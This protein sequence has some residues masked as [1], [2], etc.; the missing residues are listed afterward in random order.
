M[1]HLV[2]VPGKHGIQAPSWLVCC[3]VAPFPAQNIDKEWDGESSDFGEEKGAKCVC[4]RL[5]DSLSLL[6]STSLYLLFSLSP[7]LTFPQGDI[8]LLQARQAS[9][10]FGTHGRHTHARAQ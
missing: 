4:P 10:S 2:K 3:S 1:P 9:C 7:S 5:A 6:I 8:D